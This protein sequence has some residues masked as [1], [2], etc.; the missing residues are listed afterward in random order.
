M[1]EWVLMVMGCN[2]YTDGARVSFLYHVCSFSNTQDTV[3]NP[4]CNMY[5]QYMLDFISLKL[6]AYNQR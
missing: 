4:T 3:S 6:L 1:A 2:M 5:V